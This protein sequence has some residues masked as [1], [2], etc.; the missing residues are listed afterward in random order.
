MFT[1]IH[2]YILAIN[3]T[4]LDVGITSAVSEQ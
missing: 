4:Y 3:H 2:H 1:D